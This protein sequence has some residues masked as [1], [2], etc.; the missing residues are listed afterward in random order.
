MKVVYHCYGGA[1]ASSTAA[2]IHLGLLPADRIPTK[3]ELLAAPFYDGPDSSTHGMLNYVGNDDH[4][5]EVFILGRRQ[6]AKMMERL[7]K[8]MVKMLGKN[9]EEWKFVNCY[10]PFNYIMMLGGFSSRALKITFFGR[11]IVIYGTRWAYKKICR[12]VQQTKKEL[13]YT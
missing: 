1:H 3:E 8:E 4:G 11:P 6:Q 12:I 10:Q 2:A 13:G 5:N 9:P 7:L